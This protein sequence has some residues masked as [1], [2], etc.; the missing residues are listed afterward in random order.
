VSIQITAGTPN[1]PPTTLAATNLILHATPW[2]S[3]R[4]E[5]RDTTSAANPWQF[6]RRVPLTNDFQIIAP[7]AAAN[8]EFRAAEF[9]ADPFALELARAPAIG[10]MAVLYGPANQSFE[11]QAVTNL[12]PPVLWQTIYTLTMTNTFRILPSEPLTTPRRFFQ[13]NPLLGPNP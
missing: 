5:T 3:Y 7:R 8:R 12:A 6:L 2:R 10:V 4:V 13:V 1:L 11:V 9:V